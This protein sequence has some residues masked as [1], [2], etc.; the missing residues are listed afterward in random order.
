[1]WLAFCLLEFCTIEKLEEITDFENFWF[2][3]VGIFRVERKGFFHVGEKLAISLLDQNTSQAQEASVNASSRNGNCVQM[4]RNFPSK[5]YWLERKRGVFPKVI[6]LFWQI[7]DPHK[8]AKFDLHALLAIQL[9]EPEN[10]A[11]WKASRL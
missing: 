5:F 9:V 8:S 1:M 2:V 10:L 6:C 7:S 3:I 11:K 4:D